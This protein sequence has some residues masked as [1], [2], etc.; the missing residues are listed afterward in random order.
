[1]RV[2]IHSAL[3]T[4]AFILLFAA[5]FRCVSWVLR[6]KQYAF[7]CAPL[8]KENLEQVDLFLMGSSHM[9]NGVSP[10]ILWREQGITSLNLAQNGQVLPVTYYAVQEAFRYQKPKLLVLDIYKVVQDSLTDSSASL[11]FTLDNMAFG[12]PKL[13][14]IFDL[15]PPEE[16]AE[17]LFPIILY[18]TRWK[19]L[20]KQD[21]SPIDTSEKGAQTLFT[22]AKP[23]EG[24]EIIPEDE[25]FPP[26]QV[27]IDYL[28]KIVD[29]CRAEQV[30]LLFV[31]LPFT[32][33]ED[34]DLHRQA[35]VNSMNAYAQEWGIPFVNMMY[36]TEEMGLDFST[37]MADTYHLNQQ[38]MEKASVWLGQYL[39]GQYAL[40]DHR[41]DPA[42]QAW[43]T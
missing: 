12:L 37:D 11:H 20:D 18:H 32:T 22:A 29:L 1:M 30:D 25:T 40:T 14:A 9:L 19:E 21:F 7:A 34:D 16:R 31:A 23:Y 39:A 13:R 2:K 38:G 5:L 28:Q 4:I 36:R 10:A 24:W 33:P 8:Y 3:R 41:G 6:D 43:D 35:A 15:L 17:Y 26:A 42:Y 27:E